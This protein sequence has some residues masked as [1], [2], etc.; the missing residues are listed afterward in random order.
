[1]CDRIPETEVRFFRGDRKH[2]GK[3]GDD[4]GNEDKIEEEKAE[5]L[6]QGAREAVEKK[7]ERG[8]L[9]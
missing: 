9:S 7:G 4:N 3:F 1:M 5:A 8:R 2:S 6:P